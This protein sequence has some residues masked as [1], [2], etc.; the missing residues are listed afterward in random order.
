MPGFRPYLTV[1]SY[2]SENVSVPPANGDGVRRPSAL[3]P[4]HLEG[5]TMR[6][7]R[8]TVACVAVLTLA[9]APAKAFP[10]VNGSFEVPIVPSGGFTN[11]AGGST[12]ITGWTVVGVDSS[13]VSGTFT[14][15]GIVFQ[16]QSGNQ[17]TDLAGV[18]SNSSTSGVTQNVATMIGGVYQLSFYVGS[19]TGGP[20]FPATVDLSING[21]ARVG[22]TN[23]IGPTN[24]LNWKL[25]T[26]PFTATSTTTTI[27]FFNGSAANNFL[28]A[29]DNVSITEVLCQCPGDMNADGLKDGGDIQPFVNCFLAPGACACANMDGVGG[30]DSN[31]LDM[32]VSDLLNGVPC[33]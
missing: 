21:G 16:A 2:L 7:I 27:T 22:Y 15:S 28:C 29:L 23:P 19:A 32:F 12:G 9:A 14:Q 11:F 26:V 5:N 8:L 30:I 3:G 17:W 20:F 18:T 10:I 1:A 13:V 33:P 31:D 4:T 24:M 25:F 6:A